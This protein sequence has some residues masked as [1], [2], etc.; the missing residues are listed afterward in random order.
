[1][2][3]YGMGIGCGLPNGTLGGFAFVVMSGRGALVLGHTRVKHFVLS[4]HSIILLTLCKI[5]YAVGA[6]A[7]PRL[8]IQ[9]ST[10]GMI[11]QPF[12]F[13]LGEFLWF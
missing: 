7:E 11:C 9:Y 5:W 13:I 12:F 4:A 3:V 10:H 1:M 8:F 2:I 6:E